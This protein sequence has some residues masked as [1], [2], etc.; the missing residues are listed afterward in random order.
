MDPS[1]RSLHLRLQTMSSA[2]VCGNLHPEGDMEDP[3]D[4]G[5]SGPG[6]AAKSLASGVP[7][8]IFFLIKEQ[9]KSL[10]AIKELARSSSG[11]RRL[12]EGPSSSPFRI[13]QQT[14]QST[15][16]RSPQIRPLSSS[17]PAK[18]A[19]A[20]RSD[21]RALPGVSTSNLLD[22]DKQD[23]GLDSDCRDHGSR[24]STLAPKDELLTLLDIIDERG[25][26]LQ[27]RGALVGGSSSSEVLEFHEKELQ[28]RL[29]EMSVER[30]K[31]RTMVRQL[32][33][34]I[35]RMEGERIACEEKLQASITEKEELE[36]KVHSLHMQYVRGRRPPLHSLGAQKVAGDTD[37]GIATEESKAKVSSILKESNLLELKKVLLL[38]T[39]ENQ[40]LRKKL[41]E[42]NRQW[43]GKL[44]EW[45]AT[46]AS[47][48]SDIQNLIQEREVCL[49][50]LGRHQRDM[51]LLQAKYKELELTVWALDNDE[52]QGSFRRDE[53]ELAGGSPSLPPSILTQAKNSPLLPRRGVYG[54]HF[55]RSS[56]AENSMEEAGFSNEDMAYELVDPRPP[57]T[58]SAFAEP[59]LP[60]AQKAFVSYWQDR[61]LGA[62]VMP[63]DTVRLMNLEDEHAEELKSG[64]QSNIEMIC[65][66]FDP[67]S[68][69]ERQSASKPLDFEDSLDLSIP[70]KPVRSASL[71]AAIVGRSGL[72]LNYFPKPSGASKIPLDQKHRTLGKT[73]I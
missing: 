19:V 10:L 42:G 67:L 14:M 70:L 1:R 54:A 40:A 20:S 25:L 50:A 38:Y 59:P 62:A 68:D 45:K 49:D 3:E 64:P 7:G 30:S 21:S 18:S 29:S 36:K 37:P 56:L 41:E 15:P 47:L 71:T 55:K 5:E 43:F 6:S 66:E 39:L 73:Q 63:S 58:A 48:R 17:E 65:N 61:R 4:A 9:A 22:S 33:A 8:P 53:D 44:S 12:S 24:E 23:S 35:H 34:T 31:H 26:Q 46:E 57:K 28:S 2:V 60:P 13:I 32:Q 69:S 52:H 72:K 27:Q 11:A 51:R 16:G